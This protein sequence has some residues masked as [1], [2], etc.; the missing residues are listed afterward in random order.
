MTGT[1]WR[2]PWAMWAITLLTVAV[3]TML[4]WLATK[5]LRCSDLWGRLATV[6]GEYDDEMDV[7]VD[8]PLWETIIREVQDRG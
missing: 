6:L 3:P 5:A 2:E 1:W 8:R 4:A 7:R